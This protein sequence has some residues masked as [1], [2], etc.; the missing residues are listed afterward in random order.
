MMQE[1][2]TLNSVD[3]GKLVPGDVLLFYRTEPEE[4]LGAKK[5]VWKA[6]LMIFQKSENGFLYFLGSDHGYHESGKVEY[7][8]GRY[9]AKLEPDQHP[10][11]VK[12]GFD[13]VFAVD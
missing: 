8:L 12:E 9:F 2:R 10:E 1:L 11:V 13:Y 4:I 5:R 3:V 6:D 7:F